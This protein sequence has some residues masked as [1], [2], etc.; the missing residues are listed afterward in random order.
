MNETILAVLNVLLLAGLVASVTATVAIGFIVLAK[1]IL[2]RYDNVV[3]FFIIFS[4]MLVAGTWYAF[5]IDDGLGIPLIPW[6]E[7]LE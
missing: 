6:L 4:A 7:R 1:R 3:M 2:E 5:N